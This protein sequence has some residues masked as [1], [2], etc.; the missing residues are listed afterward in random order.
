LERGD[1]RF[2][3]DCGGLQRYGHPQLLKALL[4]KKLHA[5]H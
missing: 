5:M 3:N 2:L 1:N 4:R